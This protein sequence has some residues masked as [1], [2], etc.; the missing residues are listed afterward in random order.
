MYIIRRVIM[1]FHINEEKT[2]ERFLGYVQIDSETGEELPMCDFLFKELADM[3]FSLK[4]DVPP[5]W[6]GSNGYNIY[7]ILAGNRPAV[8]FSAHMDTVENGKNIKPQ[9]CE[10]GYVRSDGTT[11][12]G[13]D[14]KAGIAAILSA[15]DEA[16]K[17]A[18]RP[19]IEVVFTVREEVG[20]LGAKGFNYELITAKNALVLDSGGDVDNIT[21]IAP[22]QSKMNVTIH[23][24]KAHAGI[25]PES[26]ISA[27]QVGALAVSRMKLLRVDEETTSNIGTFSASGPNNIVCDSAF[28]SLEV[29]S[30]NMDKLQ[31]QID[32]LSQCFQDA[33]EEFGASCDIEVDSTYPSFS[34]DPEE[35]VVQATLKACESM[36]IKGKLIGSGGG[37]DANIFNQKGIATVN[38]AIGMEK[39]HSSKEQQSIKQMNLASEICYRVLG[40]L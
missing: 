26:G 18:D 38:L 10:D 7:G 17:L 33:C 11:I 23:G 40:H 15:V 39:V 31:A 35:K 30:R 4:K 12:L 27:I 6:V 29:R 5:S 13:G 16:K 3:G 32:H 24:R 28:L 21:V 34:L 25:S 19:T 22:A 14:D 37:S 1:E 20:L 2:L 9:V 8:L 36:G